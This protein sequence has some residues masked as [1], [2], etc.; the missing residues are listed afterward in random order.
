MMV[1]FWTV[2]IGA[3]ALNLALVVYNTRKA[4][5]AHRLIHVLMCVCLDA[6]RIRDW[7]LQHIV[8]P[9]RFMSRDEILGR[10]KE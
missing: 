8:G 6:W 7:P 4:I 2:A 1:L 10:E 3:T 5:Q 9:P